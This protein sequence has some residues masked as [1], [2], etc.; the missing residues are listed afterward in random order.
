[1][2]VCA[3]RRQDNN[4]YNIPVS[5]MLLTDYPRAGPICKVEP[6]AVRCN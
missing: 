6:S 2:N 5:F 4:T 3:L 1:M